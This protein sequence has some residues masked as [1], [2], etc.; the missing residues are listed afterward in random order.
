MCTQVFIQAYW[1]FR[2]LVL[3]FSSLTGR[4]THIKAKVLVKH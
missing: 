1:L 3:Q 4:I 2:K